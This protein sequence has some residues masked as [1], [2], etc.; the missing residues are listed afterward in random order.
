MMPAAAILLAGG[1]G[2]RLGS[3][4]DSTPKPL[5]HVAGRP[6]VFYVLDQLVAAGLTRVILSTGY[7]A[8]QFEQV[9]GSCY[10]GL[11]VRYVVEEEPL[12]TGGAIMRC[13]QVLGERAFVLNADTLFRISFPRMLALHESTQADI[14]VAVREA[15]DAFRYGTVGLRGN[16]IVTFGQ[17]GAAGAGLINGGIYLLDPRV[18]ARAPA[19]TVFSF[20]REFLP[21]VLTTLFVAGYP[22]SA[23]FIDMGVPED[24]GRAQTELRDR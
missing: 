24:F 20:E 13:L 21:G 6:F 8:G 17:G 12:G 10:G 3:L 11:D 18:C 5:L 15:P 14:T 16:R 23:Y 9:I 7:L 1:R 2:T 22:D 19:G 4:T